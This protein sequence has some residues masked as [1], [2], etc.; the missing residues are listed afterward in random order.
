M[1]IASAGRG[2]L[3]SAR[4]PP[5]H[6]PL[7]PLGKRSKRKPM[8]VKSGEVITCIIEVEQNV[9]IE[10][11]EQCPQVIAVLIRSCRYALAENECQ[12]FVC[13]TF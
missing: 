10:P 7:H 9:C 3:P 2:S 12:A 6:Q 5:L 4:L 8:F 13:S 1:S 11:F